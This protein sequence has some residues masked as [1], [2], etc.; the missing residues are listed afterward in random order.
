[1]ASRFAEA[2]LPEMFGTAVPPVITRAL[3]RLLAFDQLSHVYESLREGTDIISS[4][5][6]HMGVNIRVS[7]DDLARIPRSGPVILTCNHP[8][9]ILDGV[10]LSSALRE[11]RPDVKILANKLLSAVPEVSELLI[12][13][14]Q[15]GANRRAVT[16]AVEH[17]SRGG[18]LIVFPAGEVSRLEWRKRA[19]V[20]P[21]WDPGAAR[22]AMLTAEVTVIPVYIA[23]RNSALFH[24]A[25]LIHPRARTALLVRELL[26]K[27]NRTIEV[28]IGSPVNSTK[29]LEFSTDRERID[30]LQ[31]RTTLLG[32][33]QQF[34][35]DTRRPVRN[36]A[37]SGQAEIAPTENRDTMAGEIDL[38]PRT[39]LLG[40]S[41]ELAVYIATARQIPTVLQEI[42]RLREITF[43]AV[44]EGTGKPKD[45]DQFDQTYLH[46]FV[47]NH[48]RHEVVG[49]YRIAAT[50][51]VRSLYT[52]TLFHLEPEFVDRFG[53][54][55]EL[56][57][58]FIRI[59][60][61]RAFAPLLLLWK[62]I[63]KFVARN[64][65]WKTLFGP[66]SISN[67]YSA[68][69]RALMMS[70]LERYA[71]LPSL[72]HLVA[73]RKRMRTR[74]DLLSTVEGL[75]VDDLATAVSDVEAGGV[76]IPVLL[77]QYLKLG[78]KLL[79][80]SVDRKF[81]NVLDGLIVV[82]LTQ[83]EPRLLERYLGKE[84]AEQFLE[85]QKG[86]HGSHS[87]RDRRELAS[88]P[89]G[90]SHSAANALFQVHRST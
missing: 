23:G 41:G 53:P 25:G 67:Q 27:R 28:R 74:N 10:V 77:R 45:L 40:A 78:G 22:I 50:D 19:V 75:E 89:C 13:V 8:H 3:D 49:A 39:A 90:G 9:G 64:P 56:G 57:R 71:S 5:V 76:G 83:T 69:A 84:E 66:V 55:L 16:A 58:S 2:V 65:R 59:E 87:D 4:L 34:R 70:F 44:G 68:P 26:N 32:A 62:G 12:P 48:A 42:G 63:G 88:A 24:T 85:Y 37:Q 17:L 18:L 30:Y 33:R 73:P 38:L 14:S 20:D 35:T 54:A 60:Y 81:S 61:Q 82:D 29:L 47:W 51:Q 11:V 52:A 80:F 31:W 79:S 6:A 36:V 7:N 15:Q 72:K 46:L 1:V 86:K 21:R 43:R